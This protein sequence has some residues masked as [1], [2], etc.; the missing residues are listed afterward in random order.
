MIYSGSEGRGGGGCV[1]R[2]SY[3]S[4]VGQWGRVQKVFSVER[5]MLF[6]Q[7]LSQRAYLNGVKRTLAK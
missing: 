6:S 3:L 2:R 5:D 4:A 1:S 7:S